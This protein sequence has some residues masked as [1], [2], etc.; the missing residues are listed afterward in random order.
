MLITHGTNNS[1]R[2]LR[3]RRRPAP[4]DEVPKVW[5]TTILSVPINTPISPIK[6]PNGEHRFVQGLSAV[7][8]AVVPAHP[9][10]PDLYTIL[11]S[12]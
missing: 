3:L 11:P 2:D 6:R 7:L 10:V 5:I 4:D 8:R 1:L 12:P 9:L